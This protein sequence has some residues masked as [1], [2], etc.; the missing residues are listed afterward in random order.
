MRKKQIIGDKLTFSINTDE[1]ISIKDLADSLIAFSDEYVNSAKL[2]DGMVQ[3]TE[4]RK[5]SYIFDAIMVVRDHILPM[6]ENAQI[7]IE[8]LEN[9]NKLKKF[10]LPSDEPKDDYLPTK[11]DSEN[12]KNILQPIY[13][14]TNNGTMTINLTSNLNSTDGFSATA[15]EAKTI[16]ENANRYIKQ[17]DMQKQDEEETNDFTNKLIYF[18]QTRINSKDKGQ[19]AI[20]EEIA[21]NEMQ[22]TFA[23]EQIQNEIMDNPYHFAF[24]VDIKVHRIKGEIKVYEIT[25]MHQKI[26][27][28]LD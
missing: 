12:I 18:V 2:K 10:F 25:H 4:V 16:K 28:D 17:L 23:N 26:E 20:C 14:I 5:G 6:V 19:K 15:S 22:T 21:K 9:I 27:R 7:T 3:I 11:Q 8:F 13:N 24:F 1:P